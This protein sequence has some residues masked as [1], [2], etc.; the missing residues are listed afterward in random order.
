MDNHCFNKDV[1]AAHSA[2]EPQL[3]VVKQHW[4]VGWCLNAD[5]IVNP[6]D[7]RRRPGNSLGLLKFGPASYGA[8][9]DNLITTR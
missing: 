6:C 7:T 1:Y 8:L 4:L 5:A 2:H 3:T 9:E